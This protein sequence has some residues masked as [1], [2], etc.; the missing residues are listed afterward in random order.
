MQ[1]TGTLVKTGSFWSVVENCAIVASCCDVAFSAVKM[2]APTSVESLDTNTARMVYELLDNQN[3]GYVTAQH[4]T[5]RWLAVTGQPLPEALEGLETLTWENFQEMFPRILRHESHESP[6]TSS[7]LRRRR[8][9]WGANIGERTSSP[10]MIKS[11]TLLQEQLRASQAELTAAQDELQYRKTE[12][13]VLKGALRKA[14]DLADEQ[15]AQADAHI[16]QI[17]NDMEHSLHSQLSSRNREHQHAIATLKQ[18]IEILTGQIGQLS[19]R[20]DQRNHE[21]ALLKEEHQ[22]AERL[23]NEASAVDQSE[24]LGS[25]LEKAMASNEE[26]TN[27]ILSL[28]EELDNER[29]MGRHIQLELQQQRSVVQDQ[30]DQIEELTERLREIALEPKSPSWP[31]VSNLAQE[32]ELSGAESKLEKEL[33]KQKQ[34]TAELRQSIEAKDLQLQ[35]MITRIDGLEQTREWNQTHQP[36]RAARS[37]LSSDE[38]APVALMAVHDSTGADLDTLRERETEI[39]AIKQHNAVLKNELSEAR[40]EVASL[41]ETQQVQSQQHQE[42]ERGRLTAIR[43]RDQ[44]IARATTRLRIANGKYEAYKTHVE[45]LHQ[46]HVERTQAELQALEQRQMTM[47]QQM[48]S[49]SGSRGPQAQSTR[50]EVPESGLINAQLQSSHEA[51][52]SRLHHLQRTL[53]HRLV[54]LTNIASVDRPQTAGSSARSALNAMLDKNLATAT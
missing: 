6:E 24:K 3:Q 32:L 18:S 9:T 45:L 29:V 51:T 28:Q 44:E 41:R 38:P 2:A 15:M 31:A 25:R 54:H 46:E 53:D 43:E 40:H 8:G 52:L 34:L 1:H 42:A 50:N 14:Q 37:R 5:A 30:K 49:S 16:L 39:Y 36:S 11:L 27:V 7:P 10:L 21:Y 17:K 13:E 33:Q 20:L 48:Y 35:A 12:C 26:K 22:L 4:L 19:D 23:R 47:L